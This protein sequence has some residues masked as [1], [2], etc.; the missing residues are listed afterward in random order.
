MSQYWW[1]I[2]LICSFITA[3]YVYINQVYRMPGL[4][5]MLYRGFFVGILTLPLVLSYEPIHN[6]QFYAFCTAQGLAIAFNDY[7][8]FRAI[9]VF[10]AEV[11]ASI[12]PLAIS[13]M[14]VFWLIITP[15]Q[16]F[17]L[18]G[19]PFYFVAIIACLGGIIF[20]VIKLRNAKASGRAF[21]YL[22][23]VL[24]VL[25]IGDIL[26]KKSM[27]YGA[28]NLVSAIIYYSCIT[29][30]VCGFAN[31][32]VYIKRKQSFKPVFQKANI[33]HGLFVALIVIILMI[34]KNYSMYLTPNP[35]YVSAIILLYPL[36]IMS[37][38]NLYYKINGKQ[39]G[40]AKI[41]I[42]LLLILLIS[43]IS[44]VIIT[45]HVKV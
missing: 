37:A 24:I 26:N 4:L 19:H 40:Y 42:K 5:I 39:T 15:Q 9:K 33:I 29:G 34:F 43:I 31:L 35:A 2:A 28:E 11:S 16:L 45:T 14:F 36:W 17:A 18:L 25:A 30:F 21:I 27:Q 12:Q 3:G 23:P 38:N 1:L 20:S 32:F 6:W 22:F 44:L 7:R 8:L 10:G 41:N 13:V